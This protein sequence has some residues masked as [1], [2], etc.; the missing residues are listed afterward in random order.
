MGDDAQVVIKYFQLK[1]RKMLWNWSFT[2]LFFAHAYIMSGKRCSWTT[3]CLGY[4]HGHP[5]CVVGWV[6]LVGRFLWLLPPHFSC[7]LWVQRPRSRRNWFLATFYI[8]FAT[9]LWTTTFA[10][11]LGRFWLHLCD[12]LVI[13]GRLLLNQNRWMSSPFASTRRSSSSPTALC[14]VKCDSEWH[15]FNVQN[16]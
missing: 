1:C 15:F 5:S 2:P 12:F 13:M 7:F 14:N 9:S 4:V 8:T 16:V 11:M 10:I 6:W 3:T